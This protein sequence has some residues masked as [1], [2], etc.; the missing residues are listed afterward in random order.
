MD[1]GSFGRNRSDTNIKQRT[2][3]EVANKETLMS[4][5]EELYPPSPQDISNMFA[6]AAF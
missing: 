2:E 3:L 5:N 4:D 1:S 6:A